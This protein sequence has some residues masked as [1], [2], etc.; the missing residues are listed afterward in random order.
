MKIVVAVPDIGFKGGAEQVARDI[1]LALQAL[2]EVVVVSAFSKT[3]E[4]RIG[5]RVAVLHLGLAR[6][7]TA[8]GK[9]LMRF[10]LA[11]HMRRA[12]PGA[13]VVIGNNYFRYWALPPILRRPICVE[14]QHLCYEEARPS[15]AR[16]ALRNLLYRRLDGLAVLT[17]RDRMAFARNGV[18]Q[19]TLLPNAVALPRHDSH[20]VPRP[21]AVIAVGRLTA[22]KNFGALIEAWHLAAPSLPG[23]SLIV[24]GEGEQ[25]VMLERMIEALGLSGSASLAGH[26]DDKRAVYGSGAVLCSVS[27]YEGFPLVLYEAAAH[28]LPVV[29]FD[30]PSGPRELLSMGELGALVPWGDRRALADAM[31]RMAGDAALRARCSRNAVVAAQAFS[32]EAFGQRWRQYVEALVARRA[33]CRDVTDRG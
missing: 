4:A 31:R 15:R 1:A 11:A 3:G 5:E 20:D 6:P 21:Q 26:V 17:E 27:C 14:V 29:A 18:R 2:G 28:G 22:Q 9:I 7:R 8:L 33:A 16:L 13:D 24:Y 32:F 25:R 30:Y 19:A 10:S 23:W 12:V